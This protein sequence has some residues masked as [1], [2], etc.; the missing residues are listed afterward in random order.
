[1]EPIIIKNMTFAYPGQNALFDNCNLDIE[2]SWKLGLLGR[3]GR[4]KTTLM[5]IFQNQLD[6]TGKIQCNLNFASFPLSIEPEVT[7]YAIGEI[8]YALPVLQDEQWKVEREL[9]LLHTNLDILYQPYKSLSGGEKTK[10]QL[11]SLFALDGYYLLLDEPTNHLDQASRQ[12]LANYLKTKKTGFIITSHDRNF[13]DHVID[14]CLVIEQH[15]L[16]LEH[17]NYSTYFQQKRRRD[18]EALIVNQQLK[19]EIKQLKQKQQQRQQWAQQAESEKKNNAHADKGFIGAKAAKMMKKS[20]IMNK[21][22]NETIHEKEA[23]INEREQI[24]SLELNYR[25][26]LHKSLITAKEVSLSYYRQLFQPVSFTLKSHEQVA[27]VGNNGI[28]KSSLIKAIC[29]DFPGNISGQIDI[30]NKLQISLVRQDYSSNHGLLREF[31]NNHQL[32]Y[33]Q[34]LNTLFKLGFKRQTF[35]IPIERMSMGQQKRVELAKSLVEPAQLYIW[36]EPLNYLDTYNQEQLIALIKEYQPPILFIE[37]DQN[38][39]GEVATKQVSLTPLP[40]MIKSEFSKKY[41]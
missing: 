23:L 19:S 37:H 33:E 20:T 13:L 25:T 8:Y 35:N 18:Q 22:M 31:A 12:Q 40:K 39:I 4:G 15:Q 2:S 7:N 29:G 10:L 34:L 1:M 36:D 24:A 27:L 16:V 41:A 9:N 38:F 32:D 30:A 6:Y 5:K 14:H 28:G 3:N 17:G 21:R 11:A 26:S